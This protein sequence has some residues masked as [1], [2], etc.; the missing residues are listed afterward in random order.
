MQE[1]QK[2]ANVS[3]NA[4][5]EDVGSVVVSLGWTSASG[6]GDA[7]VSVLLVDESGKIRSENDF[8]FYNNPAA[9]DGS[10]QLLGKTP[11]TAAT[12]TAS[13]SI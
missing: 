3:L 10:V 11:P 2:G 6:A 8:Y 5:S 7:D 4:L 1:I 13:A 9:P 12:R